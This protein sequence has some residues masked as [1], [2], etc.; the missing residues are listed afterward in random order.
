MR[1]ICE[2]MLSGGPR[3]AGEV[4]MCEDSAGVITSSGGAMFYLADATSDQGQVG[5]FSSRYLAV[6]LGSWFLAHGLRSWELTAD[7]DVEKLFKDAWADM[8]DELSAEWNAHARQGGLAEALEKN[9]EPFQADGESGY[10]KSF[11]ATFLGGSMTVEGRVVSTVQVGDVDIVVKKTDG[12]HE[13]WQAPVARVFAQAMMKSGGEPVLRFFTPVYEKRAASDIACLLAKTDGV[14]F[15][16]DEMA[17]GMI[18]EGVE[19]VARFRKLL[20][21]GIRSDTGDDKALLYLAF[22]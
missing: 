8:R 5:Y 11:S 9:G 21:R 7:A 2:T 6:S 3:H 12:Q 17:M 13:R 1:F 18:G 15:W 4:G 14:R 20:R 22:L 16:N 19:A 10:L